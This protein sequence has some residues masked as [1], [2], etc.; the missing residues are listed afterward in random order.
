MCVP[1]NPTGVDALIQPGNALRERVSAGWGD[2]LSVPSKSM[3]Q[4]RLA[5]ELG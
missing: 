3:Q 5:S 1:R 2:D 4:R